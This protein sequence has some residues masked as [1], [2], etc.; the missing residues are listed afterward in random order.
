V[1]QPRQLSGGTGRL[2]PSAVS[3]ALAAVGCDVPVARVL[4]Y[5]S[6]NTRS[7]SGASLHEFIS[8]YCR[9]HPSGP[10]APALI[11]SASDQPVPD[12]TKAQPKWNFDE[13]EEE[14]EERGSRNHSRRHGRSKG[15]LA[16]QQRRQ[17]MCRRAFDRFDLNGDG[18]I[19]FS[20]LRATFLEL[21]RTASDTEL[22]IW[23]DERD[24]SGRGLVDFH[25]AY[26]F[27][28]LTPLGAPRALARAELLCLSCR[29]PSHTH[30]H[31][32]PASLSSR[33]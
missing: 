24:R 20:E 16:S 13:A 23:I 27:G 12:R 14:E 15:A 25:G 2:R 19:S 32:P 1:H 4:E 21:G 26:A 30:R 9:L 7:S 33:F 11:V 3:A 31:P 8:A 29:A 6:S 17:A 18:V 28:P 10:S 5:V 22:K